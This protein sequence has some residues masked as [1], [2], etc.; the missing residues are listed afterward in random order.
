MKERRW[1]TR[2]PMQLDVALVYDGL[3]ILRCRTRDIS[4]AGL[5][6]ETGPIVLPHHAA[7]E[8]V[9]EG[10]GGLPRP[11]CRLPALVV[12]VGEDGAGAMFRDLEA[13]G[14]NFL[15]AL[16]RDAGPVPAGV[17]PS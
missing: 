13:R 3:G 10:G 12:R 14:L 8:V 11:T 7:I 2:K 16:L 1:N 6:V 9:M 5:F 4:L 15:Q 17:L